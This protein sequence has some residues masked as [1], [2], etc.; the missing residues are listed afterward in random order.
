MV[1]GVGI[2]SGF[3]LYQRLTQTTR[4]AE[5]VK[6][7]TRPVMKA[8]IE[9]FRSK[10]ATIETPEDFLKDHRLLQFALVAFDMDGQLQYPARIKQIMLSDPSDPQ[11]LVNRMSDSRYKTINNAFNFT[12]LGAAKL[13]NASFIDSIVSRYTQNSYEANLGEISPHIPDALYFERAI[14]NVSNGYQVIGDPVLFDV[15][16]VALSIPNAAVTGSIE[17]LSDWVEKDFDFSR[18]N[19]ATY[20]KKIIDRYLVLKDVEA[21]QES[22]DNPLLGMFA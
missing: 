19:D 2:L 4:D 12:G 21:R 11:S 15:V 6:F 1:S 18:V 5:A 20:V 16:K 10:I 3:P 17:R 8:E 22:S 9:Y 14:K 13:K 7:G